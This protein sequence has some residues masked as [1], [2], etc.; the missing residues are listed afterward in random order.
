MLFKLCFG[1][2]CSPR[3]GKPGHPGPLEVITH[4]AS[5]NAQL[6]AISRSLRPQACFRRRTSLNLRTGNLRLATK[7]PPCLSDFMAFLL[8]GAAS[9]TAQINQVTD[10]G[11]P[12]SSEKAAGLLRE[13]GRFGARRW[14]DLLRERGRIRPR[15]RP[16][17][18]EKRSIH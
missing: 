18:S 7:S 14:P 1:E 13:G 4:G 17:Y 6:S 11:G 3:P 16:I 5:G 8:P 9:P 12:I 10:P 2:I 15:S